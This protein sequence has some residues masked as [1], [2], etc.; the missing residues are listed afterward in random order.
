MQGLTCE[1]VVTMF[2]LDPLVLIGLGVFLL[3]IL[4]WIYISCFQKCGPNEA[5]IISGWGAGEEDRKFKI[6]VGGGAFVNP[7][8]QQKAFLSLETMTIDVISN[9]PM[10]TKNGV[11][12]VVEGVA[13]IKVQNN[14]EAIATAAQQVLNKDTD[15]IAG[16]AHQ[17]LIGH[18]RAIL[19]TLAVEDLLQNNEAF[20]QKVQSVSAADLQNMGME[21]VSFTI[22]EVK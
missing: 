2:G 18:L 22:K 7:L 11:P 13:Q 19:G 20:S 1:G 4:G 5:M 14:N 16:I 10:I 6:V 3:F 21:I 15:Q 17:T 9:S 12:M 8:M